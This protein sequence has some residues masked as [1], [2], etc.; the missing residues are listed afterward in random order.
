MEISLTKKS[1]FQNL[2]VSCIFNEHTE[3]PC[4]GDEVTL[5]K[6]S[7]DGDLLQLGFEKPRG[8]TPFDLVRNQGTA[9]LNPTIVLKNSFASTELGQEQVCRWRF[10]APIDA[11]SLNAL[12]NRSILESDVMNCS[13]QVFYKGGW[14]Y[15]NRAEGEISLSQPMFSSIDKIEDYVFNIASKKAVAV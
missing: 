6:K 13:L 9:N 8:Q 15:V 7:P 3:N 2:T 12:D 5:T 11:Y 1:T 10:K 4:F 14:K